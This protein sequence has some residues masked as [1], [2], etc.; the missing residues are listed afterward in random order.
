MLVF[1]FCVAAV[2]PYVAAE[3]CFYQRCLSCYPQELVAPGSPV[4]CHPDNW[5][6]AQWV[7]NY[8]HP[9]PSTDSKFEQAHDNDNLFAVGNT[10]DV[11]KGCIPRAQVDS[12][13]NGLLAVERARGHSDARCF[14]CRGNNCNAA[15]QLLLHYALLSSVLLYYVLR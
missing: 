4:Q 3:S 14:I 2:L 8:G 7:H 12:V 15:S 13:C 1:I 9:P 10:V 11:L 5:V 6:S